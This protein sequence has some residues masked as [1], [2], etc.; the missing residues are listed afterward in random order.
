MLTVV[1]TQTSTQTEAFKETEEIYTRP[2]RKLTTILRTDQKRVLETPVPLCPFDHDPSVKL[3]YEL[4]FTSYTALLPED[5]HYGC[6]IVLILWGDRV[7]MYTG[8]IKDRRGMVITWA[9]ATKKQ[10]FVDGEKKLYIYTNEGVPYFLMVGHR[11]FMLTMLHVAINSILPFLS[12][13]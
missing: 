1:K 8:G 13:R 9:F 5:E 12:L 6:C 2:R 4:H 7:G 3:H 11:I 10:R